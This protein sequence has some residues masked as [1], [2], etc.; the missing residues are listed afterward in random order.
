MPLTRCW[1]PAK[2]YGVVLRSF[3]V[4][5]CAGVLLSGCDEPAKPVEQQ[6][7]VREAVTFEDLYTYRSSLLRW[8]VEVPLYWSIQRPLYTDTI[9]TEGRTVLVDHTGTAAAITSKQDLLAIESDAQ[10]FFLASLEPYSRAEMGDFEESIAKIGVALEQVYQ[11]N[12]VEYEHTAERTAIDGLEFL[13][14]TFRLDPGDGKPPVVQITYYRQF[15]D[16]VLGLLVNYDRHEAR[17]AMLSALKESRFGNRGTDQVS[18]SI[19]RVL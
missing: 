14:H 2:R 12:G 16:L 19:E 9:E 3:L 10:N 13:T 15:G 6:P 18:G 1:Q 11:T 5:T 17:V 4:A 7:E 8:E